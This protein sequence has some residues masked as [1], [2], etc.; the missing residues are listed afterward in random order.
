MSRLKS[1]LSA[2][3]LAAGVAVVVA[4]FVVSAG[5]L[6]VRNAESPTEVQYDSDGVISTGHK[7]EDPGPGYYRFYKR[8]MAKDDSSAD[9]LSVGAP[10]QG[11]D[12]AARAPA[13]A[14]SI[15]EP[16]TPYSQ[17]V[18]N[19]SSRQFYS[20]RDWTK[21]SKRVDR[22]GANYRFARPASD[23]TPAWFR[24]RIPTDGFY[25][26]YARWPS[27]DGNNPKTSFQISTASGVRRIEV[28]Q[29]RDG[30]VWVRLGAFKMDAANRYSVRVLG[31]SKSEGRII[32]DAV[33]VVAGTQAAPQPADDGAPPIAGG[34]SV[35]GGT[36]V[37][38]EILE[39]ARTHLG[40]PYRHSPPFPC[41]AYQSEDCSCF[42]SLVFSKWVQL[43]DNPVGQWY[44]GQSVEKSDLRPGDLVF[45][46]EAGP[47]HPITHV[48]IYSGRGYMIHASTF[49]GSVVES[50]MKHVH[51][52]FGARRLTG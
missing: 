1:A 34:G 14:R 52:Y 22:Y 35:T 51:G 44:V 46:K 17:I 10:S 5:A 19:A 43:P 21:S 3:S 24:V 42:T 39:R 23:M 37:E 49:W 30:G 12:P 27:A 18:D 4:I 40:T 41:Q 9:A 36:A 47:N 38:S 11:S 31:H 16:P 2:M 15:M 29:R 45:F 20:A 50:P 28:N 48:A 26:I 13:K 33:M 7:G 8:W 25:T 6:P 32:A